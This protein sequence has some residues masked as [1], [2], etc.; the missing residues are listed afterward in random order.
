MNSLRQVLFHTS[1]GVVQGKKEEKRTFI[2]LVVIIGFT[3][4]IFIT[5][6]NVCSVTLGDYFDRQDQWLRTEILII[7]LSLLMEDNKKNLLI[8]T[9]LMWH[10]FILKIMYFPL[11]KK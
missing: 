2:I 9:C 4:N 6:T 11:K 5:Y 8:I 7:G 3:N 10:F 1:R